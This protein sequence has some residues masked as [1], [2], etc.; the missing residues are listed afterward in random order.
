MSWDILPKSNLQYFLTK[1]KP[2]LMKDRSFLVETTDWVANQ[3]SGTSTDYPYVANI[4]T[5]VYTNASA[6][7]YQ[8]S[9][10]S[11]V[12]SLNDKKELQKVAD[13]YFSSSG[14]VLYATALPSIDMTLQVKGG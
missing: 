1:L 9:T 13:A 6:P 5:T 2:M 11:G 12:P 3:D 14:I 7:L 8:V 10:T 4:V